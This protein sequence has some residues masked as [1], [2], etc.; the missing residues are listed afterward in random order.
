MAVTPKKKD[1][2]AAAA[3]KDPKSEKKPRQ[4]SAGKI[5]VPVG[6]IL[7]PAL[8]KT[9]RYRLFPSLVLLVAVF[10]AHSSP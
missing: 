3:A 7:S 1:G 9:M 5:K 6:F 2:A 8:N 4:P 10:D